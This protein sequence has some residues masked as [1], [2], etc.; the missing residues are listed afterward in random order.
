MITF[1]WACDVCDPSVFRK[2]IY[3]ESSTREHARKVLATMPESIRTQYS[4]PEEFYG[5]LLAASCLEAPPPD[6][7][8]V[9][10]LMTVAELGP[11]RVAT[12]RI[13]SSA[14]FHEFQQ[15]PDGWKYVLPDAGIES[16]AQVLNSETLANLSRHP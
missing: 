15:T 9:R 2:L 14:N 4:T 8:I 3:F 13:G 11:G 10:Q 5:L 16:L 1:A 7:A 6:A 12:R